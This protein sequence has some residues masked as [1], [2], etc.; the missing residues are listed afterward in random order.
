[1]GPEQHRLRGGTGASG[2][3]APH[4]DVRQGAPIPYSSLTSSGNPG[5]ILPSVG[6]AVASRAGRPSP[7]TGPRSPFDGR[8][9][10]SQPRPMFFPWPAPPFAPSDLRPRSG[11]RPSGVLF[12]R[13]LRE[14]ATA[15]RSRETIPS[16]PATSVF[17]TNPRA[18]TPAASF[19]T[20]SCVKEGRSSRKTSVVSWKSVD[21]STAR[22]PP[23][24]RL[25]PR[26]EPCRL[27]P[28]RSPKNGGLRTGA[29][30]TA[31]AASPGRPSGLGKCQRISTSGY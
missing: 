22:R 1:M 11:P 25:A 28:G 6:R 10:Q 16:D 18:I 8:G 13:Y 19:R 4:G 23:L 30:G 3:R 24:R 29:D 20:H 31:G 21:K 9:H 5:A 15:Y 12:V 14:L 7:P 17:P 2:P 26:R 27:A